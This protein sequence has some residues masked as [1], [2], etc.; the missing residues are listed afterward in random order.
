MPTPY[1]AVNWTAKGKV[2]DVLDQGDCGACYAFAATAAIQAAYKIDRNITNLTL[3]KQ[4]LVDCSTFLGNYA[5]YGGWPDY[6]Y[7]F[8]IMYGIKSESE[9][10]YQGTAGSC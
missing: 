3:S 6:T 1:S 5:C 10:P 7:N 2:S 8:V 4:Q 9:Y